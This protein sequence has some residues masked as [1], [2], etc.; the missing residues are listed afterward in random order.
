MEDLSGIKKNT[1][2]PKRLFHWT[3]YDLQTKIEYKAKEK[4][5]DVV[6]INPQYT[7]QRCSKCG[8]TDERNRPSQSVFKCI[9]CGYERNADYNASQNISIKGIDK[10]IKE[11]KK[12]GVADI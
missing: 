6:K 5:I 3:Y 8:F 11:E 4:G 12:S 10:I 2:F 1:G 7:S 9:S